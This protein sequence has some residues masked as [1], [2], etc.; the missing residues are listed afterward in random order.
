MRTTNAGLEALTTPEELAELRAV[1]MKRKPP[2]RLQYLKGSARMGL[3]LWNVLT[4]VE[5]YPS[6]GGINGYPTFSLETLIK[7]ELI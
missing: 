5:G 7:K 4:P 1:G 6:C 3:R 2:I